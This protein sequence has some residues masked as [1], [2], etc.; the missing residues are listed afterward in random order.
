M[1]EEVDVELTSGRRRTHSQRKEKRQYS[2]SDGPTTYSLTNA[3]SPCWRVLIVH[4]WN[5]SG[6]VPS[7]R[8]DSN[9][10]HVQSGHHRGAFQGATLCSGD[11][12]ARQISPL[13]HHSSVVPQRRKP[14][15]LA[16]DRGCLLH[17]DAIFLSRHPVG[18]C[19]LAFSTLCCL[20]FILTFVCVRDSYAPKWI[21]VVDLIYPNATGQYKDL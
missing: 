16:G 21:C 7:N 6:Q 8:L 2:E 14:S 9:A 18:L 17:F 20:I 5:P 4:Q 1:A 3:L 12:N 11:I 10:W 13:R 19:P 15:R